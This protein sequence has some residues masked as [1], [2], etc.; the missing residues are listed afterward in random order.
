MDLYNTKI[1]LSCLKQTPTLRRV[2]PTSA[3]TPEEV[4]RAKEFLAANAAA[5][6]EAIAKTTHLLNIHLKEN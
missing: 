3:M 1:I 5:V 2:T 6:A 4:D